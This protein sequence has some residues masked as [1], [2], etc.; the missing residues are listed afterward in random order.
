VIII[1]QCEGLNI[2]ELEL[3]GSG[4]QGKVYK[5]DEKKCIKI[6]KKSSSCRDEVRT[7]ITSQSDSHFPKLYSYG[8]D[9]IIREYIDGIEL[10]KYLLKH[11]LTPT[12]SKKIIGLYDS[13][14]KVGF[15]R[16]DSAIFHIFLTPSG[17]LK[18][19]DTAKAM[20]KKTIYPSL[21]ISG[22]MKLGYE[23]QF[24]NFVKLMRPDLY[25]AWFNNSRFNRLKYSIRG[26]INAIYSFWRL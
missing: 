2:K 10:D 23:E 11:P 13:M 12:I 17:N 24:L 21:I 4:T 6:F 19:I 22:L 15:T 7:L 9:Y 18:L 16:L 26:E 14:K 25:N 5:I 3:L 1:K 8:K 20:K